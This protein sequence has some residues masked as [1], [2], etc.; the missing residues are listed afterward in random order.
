MSA[1]VASLRVASLSV[2]ASPSVAERSYPYRWKG[3]VLERSL[4]ISKSYST[5]F[6][7]QY[8][9]LLSKHAALRERPRIVPVRS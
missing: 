6:F 3:R 1:G 8:I 9:Y 5:L 7:S 4:I 2:A